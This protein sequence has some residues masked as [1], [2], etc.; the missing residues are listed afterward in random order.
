MKTSTF[1]IAVFALIAGL[2]QAQAVHFRGK[3]EDISGSNRFVID[4][5]N[6]ELTS[7]QFDL[8]QFLGDQVDASGTWNGSTTTPVIEVTAI[9]IVA[10]LF[11]VGGNGKIG[12]EL[13]FEVTSNPGD[14]TAVFASIASGFIPTPNAGTFFLALQPL[15]LIGRG[16]IPGGGTLQLHVNVPNDP[17]LVG[18][19]VFGQALLA[20]TA[21]GTLWSNPDCKTITN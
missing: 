16:T 10:R 14:M 21:G 19:T 7:S 1:L 11:E 8:N 5:T 9:Q 4:C 20:F 18:I 3:V 15:L 6:V 2:A 13:T 17:A 12:G